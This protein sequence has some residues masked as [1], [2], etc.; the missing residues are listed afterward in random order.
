MIVSK[1]TQDALMEMIKMCFIENR[2]LDRLVSVLGVKFA[3]NN[4]SNLI[5]HGIAHYFPALSDKI[6]ELRLERY[7]ISVEY[8]DTPSGKENYS[9]V[10][11][12]ISVLENRVIEFQTAFMG[13]CKIAF[14]NNDIHVF[15]DLQTLLVDYN[16][17]V[18]QCILL[19]DKIGIYGEDN[20]SGF[21]SHI[22]EH[23]WILGGD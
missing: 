17:I 20:I 18:E 22:K 23:F 13:L 1:S 8:G 5:H 9:S 15:T 4:S 2:K 14:D 11:E 6:G 16:K 3:M 21:D 12:I 10:V 7:N 19:K